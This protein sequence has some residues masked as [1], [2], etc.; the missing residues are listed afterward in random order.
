MQVLAVLAVGLSLSFALPWLFG[1]L[2]LQLLFGSAYV[3][4]V[5]LLRILWITTSLLI[6][7]V[8]A[9]HYLLAIEQLPA[10]WAYVAPC[11]LLAILLWRF[12]AST[13]EVALCGLASI[14]GGFFLTA[15][16]VWIVPERRDTAGPTPVGLR[17]AS[18]NPME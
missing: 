17:A 16:F 12:H 18:S 15:I 3:G 2:M 4:A 10:A 6:L 5:S 14:T 7:Q 1:D 8:A 11:A 9:S 13:V